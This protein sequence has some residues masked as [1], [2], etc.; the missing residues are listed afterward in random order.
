MISGFKDIR[1]SVFEK[2]VPEPPKRNAYG[3]ILSIFINFE[4]GASLL[5]TRR[6]ENGLRV[7]AS[8][9]KQ[10]GMFRSKKLGENSYRVWRVK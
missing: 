1:M 10:S 6:V 4:V 9:R 3:L 7:I 5:T 2:G 8:R